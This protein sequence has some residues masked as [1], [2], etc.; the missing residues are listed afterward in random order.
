MA[1]NEEHERQIWRLDLG[2]YE[3]QLESVES[4]QRH[5]FVFVV[6]STSSGID[7]VESSPEFTSFM[8]FNTGP[9]V[10]LLETVLKFHHAQNLFLWPD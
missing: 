4:D 6:E 3:V 7:V 9:A 8:R 10:P 2:R 1:A 5:A